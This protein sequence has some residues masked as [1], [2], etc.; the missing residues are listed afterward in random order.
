MRKTSIP[1]TDSAF[2]FK[3]TDTF[4]LVSLTKGCISCFTAINCC[5]N[6]YFHDLFPTWLFSRQ[7]SSSLFTITTSN[8]VWCNWSQYFRKLPMSFLTCKHGPGSVQVR[9]A[10]YKALYEI[11][12]TVSLHKTK[13][14]VSTHFLTFIPFHSFSASDVLFLFYF[15]FYWFCSGK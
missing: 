13:Q 5:Q 12:V 2:V 8:R 6:L 3:I 10:R 15:Y 1:N 11:L 7:K 4:N 14:P 9:A